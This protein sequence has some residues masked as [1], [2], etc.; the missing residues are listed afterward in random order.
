MKNRDIRK[1]E[2]AITGQIILLVVLISSMLL[3]IGGTVW[4]SNRASEI[5]NHYYNKQRTYLLN[6]QNYGKAVRSL[7]KYIRP[8]LFMH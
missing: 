2:Y 1:L 5:I 4:Y 7:E 8:G 3:I 6:K